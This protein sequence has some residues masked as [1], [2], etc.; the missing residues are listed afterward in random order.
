M[1]SFF[2][3]APDWNTNCNINTSHCILLF[4]TSGPIYTATT[5]PYSSTKNT[6][7]HIQF[8]FVFIAD[9]QYDKS[10]DIVIV[11]HFVVRCCG[12]YCNLLLHFS[13]VVSLQRRQYSRQAA[14][15]RSDIFGTISDA[16]ITYFVTD[17]FH[18]VFDPIKMCFR[19][20]D[21]GE[22]AGRFSRD[23]SSI[24]LPDI[25]FTVQACAQLRRRRQPIIVDNK[26][27]R[28]PFVSQPT[29]LFLLK[30][31]CGTMNFVQQ[32]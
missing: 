8:P 1:Y 23:G 20:I 28:L 5:D 11:F 22:T 30:L 7:N 10:S 25:Q 15:K 32:N 21:I 13:G 31:K 29:E 4:P 3:N 19:Y 14:L 27:R 2:V 17:V 24:S 26:I 18:V 12:T 9:F 16:K 6:H